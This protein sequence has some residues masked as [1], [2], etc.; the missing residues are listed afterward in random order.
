MNLR[1]LEYFEKIAELQSVGAAALVVHRTQPAL[2]SCIRRL[3]EDCGAR[4]LERSG[5]GIK[6]TD[7]GRTM[8]RWAS[9]IRLVVGDAQREINQVGKGLTGIV[10]LGI[11]PTAA[12]ISLPNVVARLFEETPDIKLQVTVGVVDS[13]TS[14]LTA[15]EI[16]IMVAT[17]RGSS[18]NLATHPIL[19]DQIVVV[20][21]K[22]HPIFD[23]SPDIRRLSEYRWVVEAEESPTRKWLEACFKKHLLGPLKVQ[24]EI[25]IP[26]MLPRLI[27]G[28]LHLGFISRRQLEALEDRKVLKEFRL[29]SSTM[30]RRL[31][32]SYVRERYRSPATERVVDIFSDMVSSRTMHKAEK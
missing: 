24:M 3:E 21:C 25:N 27:E 10:K 30:S 22:K 32:L 19:D 5:R 2:T 14:M 9:H 31:A 4:L 7:A 16:D 23:S 17:E 13:L 8:L 15:G 12:Y 18:E 26:T 11:A 1:D 20:A 6:L 29:A 28:T